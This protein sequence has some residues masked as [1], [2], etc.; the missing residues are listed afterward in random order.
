MT[1]AERPYSQTPIAHRRELS[2][3]LERLKTTRAI[4]ETSNWWN[5]HVGMNFE[6]D[7]S[8]WVVDRHTRID[9]KSGW[10]NT[11]GTLLDESEE[12]DKMFKAFQIARGKHLYSD[13]VVM[14][15]VHEAKEYGRKNKLNDAVVLDYVRDRVASDGA[16]FDILG[17]TTQ[18][19]REQ[20]LD[21][22]A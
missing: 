8:S 6:E 5:E 10:A 1:V 4:K 17:V 11:G 18:T 16:M 3:R 2:R 20:L 12:E 22:V 14:K 13:F 21:L 15:L 7:I 9:A 19:K